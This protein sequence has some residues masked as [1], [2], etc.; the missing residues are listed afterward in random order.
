MNIMV[1]TENVV[2]KDVYE[3]RSSVRVKKALRRHSG[4]FI[5]GDIAT[6][7]VTKSESP[8]TYLNVLWTPNPLTVSELRERMINEN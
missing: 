5:G 1:L 4:L 2:I 8:P 3:L 6:L 7:W